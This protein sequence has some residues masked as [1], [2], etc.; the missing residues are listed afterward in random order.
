MGLGI[1]GNWSDGVHRDTTWRFRYTLYLLGLHEYSFAFIF[2]ENHRE[3][4]TK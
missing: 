1:N 3:R 2:V 4:W